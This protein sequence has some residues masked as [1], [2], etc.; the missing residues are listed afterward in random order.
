ME[1]QVTEKAV[2]LYEKACQ[3]RP[4]D[5]QWPLAVIS[6]TQ[7]SGNYHKSLQLLKA[8]HSKFPDN[9]DFLRLLARLGA[10]LGLKEAAQYAN[11]LRKLEN[12]GSRIKGQVIEANPPR[13]PTSPTPPPPPPL[14][15]SSL[16]SIS[17]LDQHEQAPRLKT[18]R[19][20]A[21][22]SETIDVDIG[23][24]LLPL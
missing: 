1:L 8:A 5:P 22:D 13:L 24:D 6:C 11:Q 7:R 19:R 10:D 16:Q 4:S 14:S 20:L 23:E 2:T 21:N 18:A 12:N 3:L 9:A 15:L 17:A